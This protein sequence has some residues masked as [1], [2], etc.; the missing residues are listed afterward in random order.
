MTRHTFG[1][2]AKV[3]DTGEWPTVNA[4]IGIA[5]FPQDAQ[6]ADELIACAERAVSDA[7]RARCGLAVYSPESASVR[8]ALGDWR[9]FRLGTDALTGLPSRE[10]LQYLLAVRWSRLATTPVSVLH[11][12]IDNM[13]ALN[14]QRGH[15][16]GERLLAAV[17]LRLRFHADDIGVASRI[18]GDAFM[19]LA[20]SDWRAAVERVR[21]VLG[22]PFAIDGETVTITAGIGVVRCPQDCADVEN[23]FAYSEDAMYVAKRDR[24]GCA[25][26][27][28]PAPGS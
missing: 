21:T 18:A 1:E 6:S 4:R 28:P 13:H 23:L 24:G 14:D 22:E 3:N 17:G 8:T 20:E 9:P 25:L 7:R 16:F 2:W 15:H 26:Y 11:I 27:E 10:A 5:R 12:D 19:V